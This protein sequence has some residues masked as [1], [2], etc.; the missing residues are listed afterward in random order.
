MGNSSIKGQLTGSGAPLDGRRVVSRVDCVDWID[1]YA[2][3]S[4]LMVEHG[5]V[6]QIH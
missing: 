2:A 6:L 3:K 5:A 4:S 1:W